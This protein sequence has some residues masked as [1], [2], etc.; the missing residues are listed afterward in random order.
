MLLATNAAITSADLRQEIASIAVPTLVI[1]GDADLSAPL[2]VT[3]A[4]TAA[5][6]RDGRLRVIA[7]AGHGL[8][9]SFAAEYD[10]ALVEFAAA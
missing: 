5:L 1:H 6:L 4:P 8:Y 9:T 3:G 7:G 10:A 2:Q